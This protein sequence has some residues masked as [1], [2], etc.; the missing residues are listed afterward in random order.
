MTF[1]KNTKTSFR[2]INYMN[3]KSP[4]TVVRELLSLFRTFLI[5]F[6]LEKLNLP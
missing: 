6:E 1:S 2:L 3:A 5:T 4:R